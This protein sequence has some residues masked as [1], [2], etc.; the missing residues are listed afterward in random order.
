MQR[1]LMQ[2]RLYG[3]WAASMRIKFLCAG[4]RIYLM[5]TLVRVGVRVGVRARVRVGVRA[6]VRV[7]VKG[8]GLPPPT[9]CTSP[10]RASESS[11]HVDLT[12]HLNLAFMSISLST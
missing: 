1:G 4:T 5:V 8:L 6:R 12:L 10:I 3:S 11:L 7:R 2:Q 9:L